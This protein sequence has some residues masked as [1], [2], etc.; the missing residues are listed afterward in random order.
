MIERSALVLYAVAI[1]VALAFYVGPFR[2]AAARI[3]S[4]AAVSKRDQSVIDEDRR[5]LR[6][7]SALRSLQD[8]VRSAIR[9]PLQADSSG[10][11]QAGFFERLHAVARGQS[12]TLT[13]ILQ[14]TEKSATSKA[15][16]ASMPMKVTV[17]GRLSGV[18]RFLSAIDASVGLVDFGEIEIHPATV[19]EGDA[20]AVAVRISGT[21]L[22]VRTPEGMG[23]R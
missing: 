17:V 11:G 22:K 23:D 20:S 6:Q 12:V 2:H 4:D 14:G 19:K 8:R 10:K 18:L 9:S 15:S 21:F 13:T 7:A 16:L 5:L 3:A 1:G